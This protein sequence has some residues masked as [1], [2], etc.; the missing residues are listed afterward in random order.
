MTFV[1]DSVLQGSAETLF[2]WG[3]KINQLMI[4]SS[5]GNILCQQ[6]VQSE[7]CLLKLL[8]KMSCFFETVYMQ[9][10]LKSEVVSAV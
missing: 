5:S 10:R 9:C 6:I 2:R 4:A 8:L 7:K 3:G 1:F